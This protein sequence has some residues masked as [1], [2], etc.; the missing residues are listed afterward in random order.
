MNRIIVNGEDLDLY[1]EDNINLNMKVN[2]I[3]DISTRNSTYSNTVKIPAT[4]NNKRIFNY[5]GIIGN[6]SRKPYEKVRCKYIS[7]NLPLINNGYL[8]ITE[9]TSKEFSIVLFDG[10]IDLSE[11][12]GGLNLNDL[13]S[14]IL[15]NHSRNSS[16][17]VASLSTT[18]GFIYPFA[19]YVKD[20]TFIPNVIEDRAKITASEL[21]PMLFVKTILIAIIEEAGYTYSGDIFT[22]EEFENEVFSMGEGIVGSTIDFARCLPKISQVDFLKDVLNRYGLIIRLEENNIEFAYLEDILV[23]KYGIVDWTYK[24]NEIKFEKYNT[25]YTQ[26]IFTPSI[27]QIKIILMVMVFYM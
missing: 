22:N 24:L 6:I 5:L 13:R 16:S 27:T 11:K 20:K 14:V 1:P 15:L 8:Q 3:S 21:M 26:K 23:G 12:I 25:N 2:D 17:V 7:N 4:L 18:E 10:I 9:T 19:N